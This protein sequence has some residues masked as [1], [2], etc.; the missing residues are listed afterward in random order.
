MTGRLDE[1]ETAVHSIV[2]YVRLAELRFVHQVFVELL[3][4]EI[5][6]LH[7]AVA[8]IEKIAEARR[9]DEI[10]KEVDFIFDQMN[11]V[12]VYSGRLAGLKRWA[13]IVLVVNLAVEQLIYERRFSCVAA[14][15]NTEIV[16]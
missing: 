13:R 3:L 7:T 12:H 5:H 8:V 15:E 4:N 2:R 6:D 16:Y 11:A 1:V 14:I 10:E 9:V